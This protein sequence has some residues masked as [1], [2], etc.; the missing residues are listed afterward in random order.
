MNAYHTQFKT[1]NLKKLCSLFG[2]LFSEKKSQ[3]KSAHDT[4]HKPGDYHYQ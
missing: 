2:L 1:D 3:W 4:W